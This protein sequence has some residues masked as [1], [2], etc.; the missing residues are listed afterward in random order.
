MGFYVDIAEL[1]K[2]Q[3]AYMKMVATAQSQLGY[4]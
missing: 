4:R 1:Q 2:A 3:E